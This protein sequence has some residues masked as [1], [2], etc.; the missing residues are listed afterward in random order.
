[1]AIFNSYFV[2]QRVKGETTL[3]MRTSLRTK[4]A[5]V[6]QCMFNIKITTRACGYLASKISARRTTSPSKAAWYLDTFFLVGYQ[7]TMY[8]YM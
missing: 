1:M 3:Y 4:T 5:L 7:A 6:T 2:Y 8:I